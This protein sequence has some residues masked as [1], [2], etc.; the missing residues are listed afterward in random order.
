MCDSAAHVFAGSNQQADEQERA[1]HKDNK[2]PPRGLRRELFGRRDVSQLAQVGIAFVDAP[3]SVEASG[4]PPN[5]EIAPA[6]MTAKYA[7]GARGDRPPLTLTW[8]QGTLKPAILSEGGIPRWGDGVLFIGEKGM[9]L[10]DYEKHLLLPE[11]KF[12]GF[13]RP[14]PSI[15]PSL[16]HHKEWLHAAKTG[17][18]TTCHFGYSGPLTIANHLGNVAYRAG[19]RIEWDARGQRIPNAPSAEAF[20]GREYR[21]GWTLG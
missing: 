6:S 8:Y 21:K 20:L 1:D 3:L 19:K 17:A 11:E 5:P 14:Q 15:P 2:S 10:A 16:G 18:P 13:E 9:L 4:P 7:Y 12:K